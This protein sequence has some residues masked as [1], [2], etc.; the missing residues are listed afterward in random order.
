MGLAPSGGANVIHDPATDSGRET[1]IPVDLTQPLVLEIH[2]RN[3][4]VTIR[5]VE[6]TDVLIGYGSHGPSW[7]DPDND[8]AALTINVH[9]NRIE[10]HPNPR[11][12]VGWPG[13]SGEFDLESVFGQISKAFRFG[14]PVFSAKPGKVRFGSGSRVW[15][16]VAIEV[17]RAMT[18]RV[19]VHAASGDVHV[20]GVAGEIALETM[21]G[22]LRTVRTAGSIE[23]R[24][25]SGDLLVEDATGR[26]TVHAVSG[27]I[28]IASSRIDRFEFQTANGDIFVDAVLAGDGPFRAQTASGDVRLSLRRS[29]A[30]GAEPTAALVFHTVSGDADVTPPF[31]KIDRRRWQSGSG[32]RLP[33]I[34]ITTINGDLS[35]TIAA[36]ESVVDSGPSPAVIA[37]DAPP[38]PS[39]PSDWVRNERN[40]ASADTRA[41]VVRSTTLDNTARLAV[42]DAVERGEIDVEEALR[43]LDAADAV[44]NS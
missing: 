7:E 13:V 8:E 24:A 14:G 3:G 32:D 17:P 31:R 22:N 42:L 27:D 36:T 44:A 39:E 33:Q 28:R 35:A 19:E 10:V 9:G 43:R 41:D 23:M 29:A 34:D 12:D 16:D 30:E 6:R 40:L 20:D 2:A 26:F 15:P 38:A 4:D 5:A 21:S 18:C 1:L 37:T 11:V 25:A